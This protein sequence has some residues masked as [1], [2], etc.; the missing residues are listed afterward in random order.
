M[1]DRGFDIAED[2][3]LIGVKLNILPFMRG[4]EQ[5]SNSDPVMIVECS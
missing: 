2:L 4:K 3:A 1:A 5:L